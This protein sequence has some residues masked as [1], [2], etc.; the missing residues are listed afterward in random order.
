MKVTPE[1]PVVVGY[2]PV[3]LVSL[4]PPARQ[5]AALG[6]ADCLAV[7]NPPGLLVAQDA[8]R[9]AAVVGPPD[10]VGSGTEA[11][12][13]PAQ[14]PGSPWSDLR[15]SSTAS[16]ASPAPGAGP[17]VILLPAPAARAATPVEHGLPGETCHVVKLHKTLIYS[18]TSAIFK[19]LFAE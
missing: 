15:C 17:L 8:R 10:M 14:T 9:E 11:K 19:F 2:S 16:P 7:E 4:G 3:G 5:A 1:T 18:T 12:V 6:A 13:A